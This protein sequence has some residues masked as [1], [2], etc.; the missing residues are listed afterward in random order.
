LPRYSEQA[1]QVT[2]ILLVVVTVLGALLAPLGAT[3]RGPRLADVE[4]APGMIL[5][6]SGAQLA[7][8]RSSAEGSTLL[9]RSLV[10]AD[11]LTSVS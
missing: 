3:A 5:A 4:P 2:R 8:L 7:Y 1:S 9:L 6:P 11:P 10:P